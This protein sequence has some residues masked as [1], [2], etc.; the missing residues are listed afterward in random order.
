MWAP[1]CDWFREDNKMDE[2]KLDNCPCCGAE[3]YGEIIEPHKHHF[4]NFPDSKGCAFA[5]CK[6]G[7]SMM[8]ETIDELKAKWNRRASGWVSDELPEVELGAILVSDNGK[9]PYVAYWSPKIH[10]YWITEDWGIARFTHW[11]PLPQPP[12][13]VK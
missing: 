4:T 11:M 6:C 12:K 7:L 9:T 10:P 1:V 13:E 5:E 2:L 3:V 8:A